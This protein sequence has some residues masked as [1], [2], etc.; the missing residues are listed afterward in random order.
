MSRSL[1][2]DG[3]GSPVG[4]VGAVKRERQ[5]TV[6]RH[7]DRVVTAYRFATK[8][9]TDQWIPFSDGHDVAQRPRVVENR[10]L[11]FQFVGV[12]RADTRL[13]ASCE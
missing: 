11:P 7:P 5:P 12:F 4:E 8:R 13:A 1:I 9:R 10:K 2:S 3:R 6:A